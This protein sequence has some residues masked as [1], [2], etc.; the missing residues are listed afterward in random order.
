MCVQ[1]EKSFSFSS[2]QSSSSPSFPYQLT[3]RPSFPHPPISGKKSPPLTNCS[4]HNNF[5]QIW[6]W[7]NVVNTGFNWKCQEYWVVG[8]PSSFKNR[9]SLPKKRINGAH[10]LFSR[11]KTTVHFPPLLK[12]REI[13]TY[14]CKVIRHEIVPRGNRLRARPAHFLQE[15]TC[16]CVLN[17]Y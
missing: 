14:N 17:K 13:F 1:D 10:I 2:F 7:G 16:V 4:T 12:P 3:T 5:P 6:S 11:T 9:S 15:A 8:M